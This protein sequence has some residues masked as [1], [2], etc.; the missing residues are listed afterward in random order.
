[1]TESILLKDIVRERRQE[2]GF[3][4]VQ[5]GLA[6]GIASGEFVSMIETGR[7]HFAWDNVPKV[8]V[9]LGLD[10]EALCRCAM[11]ETAPTFYRSVFGDTKPLRPKPITNR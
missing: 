8:A 7:R 9:V 6:L 1:M 11:W 5:L 4:Q 3:T 2:L 10:A